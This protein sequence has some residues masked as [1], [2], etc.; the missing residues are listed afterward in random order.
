M[1][2]YPLI[3][4]FIQFCSISQLTARVDPHRTD[5]SAS[6]QQNH[7][8]LNADFVAVWHLFL[9]TIISEVQYLEALCNAVDTV[10]GANGTTT[11]TKWLVVAGWEVCAGRENVGKVLEKKGVK[12]SWAAKSADTSSG[13]KYSS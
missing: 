1:A 10:I 9:E 2:P 5:F 6:P 4:F 8:V 3:L 11:D 13:W 7:H 12:D